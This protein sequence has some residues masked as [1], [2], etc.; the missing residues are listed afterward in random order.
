MEDDT[1]NFVAGFLIGA[2]FALILTSFLTTKGWQ[3]ESVERGYAHYCPDSGAWA[4]EGEC[5]Q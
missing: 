2:G 5:K 1:I 3:Q 4:W